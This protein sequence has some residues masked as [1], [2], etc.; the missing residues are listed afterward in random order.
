MNM[1]TFENPLVQQMNEQLSKISPHL[2]VSKASCYGEKIRSL[3]VIFPLK[4]NSNLVK[5]LK[6]LGFEETFKEKRNG[7]FI[8]RMELYIHYDKYAIYQGDVGKYAMLYIDNVYDFKRHGLFGS[9]Y[10]VEFPIVV[11]S[12]GGRHTFR[13]ECEEGFIE[14][15]EVMEGE[16]PLTREDMFPKNS[17]SFLYGWIDREGNTYACS[18]EGHFRAAEALCQEKGIQCYNDERA[19]EE[20]GWIKIS[21]KAPYTPD[22]V[23]SKSIYF[24]SW[25]CRATQAQIDKLYDLGLEDDTYFK[26]MLQ[27][28]DDNLEK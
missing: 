22:N 7:S 15:K 28:M 8:Q 16:E 4:G 21:R 17:E 25:E 2:K 10:D 5:S 19:L 3:G 26:H 18:F 1:D 6:R 20:A 14:I 12:R 24:N 11:N 9:P 13:K 27:E 23:G